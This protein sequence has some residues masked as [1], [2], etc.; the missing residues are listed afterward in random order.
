[1]LPV[2]PEMIKIKN[3]NQ[4]N[5][6]PYPDPVQPEVTAALCPLQG[7]SGAAVLLCGS[8]GAAC[9]HGTLQRS[10]LGRVFWEEK[11]AARGAAAHDDDKEGG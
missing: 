8:D 5:I 11:G 9:M 4:S 2:L 7:D 10:L 6:T 3:R 1:M